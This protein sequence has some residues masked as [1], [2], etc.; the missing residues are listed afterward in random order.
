[1]WNINNL[2]AHRIAKLALTILVSV[3]LPLDAYA[4]YSCNVKVINVLIYADG[5]VNV[6]HSGRGDYTYIC[7]VSKDYAG[8]STSTCAMWTGML[9][10]LKKKDGVAEF[11]YEGNSTCNMLPTYSSAPTPFYIGD[12]TP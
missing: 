4:A 5:T 10:S 8:I 2:I 7:N 9:L 3:S 12:V 6:M 1:M 11:Y